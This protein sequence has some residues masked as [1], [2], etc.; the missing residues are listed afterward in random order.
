MK[1]ENV[2]YAATFLGFTIPP[3]LESIQITPGF[4]TMTRNSLIEL[5]SDIIVTKQ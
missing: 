2:R 4:E 1:Q 3:H 5:E